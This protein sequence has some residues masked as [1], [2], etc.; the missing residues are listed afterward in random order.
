MGL[1]EQ[2][3]RATFWVGTTTFFAK[4]VS[5][6]TILILAKLLTP[7]DFGLIAIATLIT[8]SIG[9]FR[10]LGLSQA[11]IYQ[12]DEID[13]AADAAFFMVPINSSV[14]Y[15]LAFVSAPFIASF[16]R[17]AAVTS[18]V[19][20]MALSLII[21][22]FG[23]VPS[24]LFEKELE[25]KKK[26][27]PDAVHLI[28]YGVIST[29]LAFLEFRYWSMAIGLLG[30]DVAGLISVWL[31]SDWRPKLRFDKKIAK[32]LLSYGKYITGSGVVIFAI[33]NIDDAFI[34]RLLG[35]T[36]LGAYNFAY[37]IANFPATN[38][39]NILGTV[40]FPAFSKIEDDIGA[41]REAFFKMFKYI[42]LLTIPVS[43]GIIAITPEFI[44][45]AY[46]TK[47]LSAILPIQIL[48]I[49]GLLRSLPTNGSLFLAKGRADILFKVSSGQLLCLALLLYPSI[50][51]GGVIGVCILLSIIL[52]FV[53]ITYVVKLKKILKNSYMEFLKILFP[54]TIISAISVLVP[55][56]ISKLIWEKPKFLSLCFE[57]AFMISL[58][59][60]VVLFTDRDLRNL[61]RGILTFKIFEPSSK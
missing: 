22:S 47:W 37:R 18:L 11:L 21:S 59:I 34:G 27:I 60:S 57:I 52:I 44:G 36:V 26:A 5:F 4:V 9:L 39:T 19:R 2:V 50:R 54:I 3:L 42:S 1:K 51:I 49:Y 14:L 32:E 6:A 12:K 7:D 17:N 45:L 40:A 16:F 35:T 55:M 28:T 30:A 10:H 61:V 20:V 46:G 53:A 33:R 58:Y 31:I 38:I 56:T 43:F 25:F 15:L 13:K 8:A 48:S 23:L 24:A 29:I 41:L